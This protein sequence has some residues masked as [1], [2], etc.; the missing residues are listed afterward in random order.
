MLKSA[1][2][3]VLLS[4]SFLTACGPLLE[5][6]RLSGQTLTAGQ[7]EF[8]PQYQP[9]TLATAQA[10]NSVSF[11]RHV[12]RSGA[13]AKADLV[14]EGD[15]SS[16]VA[17]PSVRP[18]PYRIGTG[19]IIQLTI[20]VTERGIADN[21]RDR[22]VSRDARVSA[23]G[24]VLLLETGKIA[25]RGLTL[26]AAREKVSNALIRNGV[27][28]RFQLEITEFNSQ[29][30]N[31]A[32]VS[33]PSA[34]GEDGV[35]VSV[36]DV[37]RGTGTY[38]ITE[39]P[40]SIK[41]LLVT[42]GLEISRSGVQVVSIDRRG[43]NYHMPVDHIFAP[44]SPEYYLTGGDTVR[45]EQFPYKSEKAFIVG[46]GAA[47]AAFDIAPEQRQTLADILFIEGG[48]FATPSARSKEIYLLR[49]TAPMMAYHLD[50]Q[51]PSR[52]RVAAEMELRPK[53]IVFVT[54][55][56]IYSMSELFNL[57]NPLAVFRRAV[58]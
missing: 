17:P 49:G 19:D 15:L 13:G 24:S 56:P 36:G 51:D 32:V 21:A 7:Q 23:D 39:R 34:G 44:G 3:I 54:S 26:E 37:A 50:A 28:P 57:V 8:D 58:Q 6:Q 47:P 43:R 46:G 22:A 45:V 5:E 1:L 31:L 14:H 18:V 48:A 20:F 52:L 27:D 16:I 29:K 2:P 9:L 4:T 25:L 12:S 11:H 41:E 42:A 53:D 35:S 40:L 30:V 55:K 10:L 33:S 38:E